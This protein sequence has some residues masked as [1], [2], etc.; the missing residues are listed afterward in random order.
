VSPDGAW[1]LYHTGGPRLWALPLR[2]TGDP[3][4]LVQAGS[5]VDQAHVSPD[6][7]WV[8]FDSNE[9][10]DWDVY[11]MPFRR[12]GERKR[13]SPE[14]GRQP[15][16]RGD[17]REIFYVTARGELISVDVQEVEGRLELGYPRAL[18][19]AG[20]SDP[21]IG[22]Y[23]VSGDGERFLV[24]TPVEEADWSVQVVLNWPALL[25]Q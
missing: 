4:L 23:G 7:R 14:G 5:R 24:V 6:G 11:V 22:N 16:W 18:F 25:E 17:G 8:V 19:H 21:I 12:E 20:V 15:L 3:E 1:L 13:V 9:A 2:G 10:G